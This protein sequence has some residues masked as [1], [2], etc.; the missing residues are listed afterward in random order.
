MTEEEIRDSFDEYIK[1][2]NS[3]YKIATYP[4]KADC[5]AGIALL[6]EENILLTE[7]IDFI[8]GYIVLLKA[9]EEAINEANIE[10]KKIYSS[11]VDALPTF[12][13]V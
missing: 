1:E 8:E 2:Q 5:E 9:C 13:G 7:E 11:D 6:V 3:N 4:F 12:N 10:V